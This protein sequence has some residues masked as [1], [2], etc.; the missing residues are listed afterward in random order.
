MKRIVVLLG[1][2]ALCAMPLTWGAQAAPRASEVE[3]SVMAGEAPLAGSLVLPQDAA[4]VPLVLMVSGSGP[5]DR[6]GNG[7]GYKNDSLRLLAQALAEHNIASLRFDKRGIGASRSGQLDEASLSFEHRIGEVEAWLDKVRQDPRFSSI[8]VLGHSEGALAGMIAARRAGADK[9]IAIAGPGA[10]LSATLRRQLAPKL[11][12]E[13]QEHS[14]RIL[15]R[16]ENGQRSDAV[17]AALLVLYRPSVQPYLISLF[18]YQPTAELAKLHI[19]V[20]ILQGSA[21][22][23]VEV[24]DARQLA[25]A[26]PQAKTAIIDGMDHLLKHPG[27]SSEARLQSYNNDQLPIS[28]ELVAHITRFLQP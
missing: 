22:L 2:A 1:W 8:T 3:V 21:D 9:F 15:Q 4:R 27:A 17:P 23:Q 7:P 11:P 10:G 5:T 14:E 6:N 16:L 20:L 19:P 24:A 28:A 26:A 25:A 12:P 18:K 13:L